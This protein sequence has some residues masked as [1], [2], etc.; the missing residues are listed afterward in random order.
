MSV[1]II[2]VQLLN[3]IEEK[4]QKGINKVCESN[5]ISSHKLLQ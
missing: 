3:L 2:F 4:N 5:D 1:K